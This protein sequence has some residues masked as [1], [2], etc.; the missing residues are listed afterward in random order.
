[1]A[2]SSQYESSD[3]NQDSGLRECGICFEKVREKR[4][5]SCSH[6]FCVPCLERILHQLSRDHPTETRIN[7]PCPEC[8]QETLMDA[9]LGASELP[10]VFYGLL[11][12]GFCQ[13]EK[14]TGVFY[15]NFS[16]VR[17]ETITM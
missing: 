11:K 6:E 16:R 10:T 15:R 1:M 17:L 5:L 13:L 7:V 3:G 2:T 14:P 8:R 4:I 9:K 12:C